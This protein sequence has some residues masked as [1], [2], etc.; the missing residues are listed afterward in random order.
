MLLDD[1]T[2]RIERLRAAHSNRRVLIGIAGPPGAGKSTLA[3]ALTDRLRAHCT[4]VPMDGFHLDDAA[5]DRLGLRHRK[6]APE[7]F[8]AEGYAA[9]LARIADGWRVWAPGFDRTVEEP[10]PRGIW[11]DEMRQVVVSEGNYLLLPEPRWQA[12]RKLFDEVWFCDLDDRLRRERL[13]KRHVEFGKSPDEAHAWVDRVDE[14][15]AALVRRS[16]HLAD[17]HVEMSELA[18][19]GS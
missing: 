2:D 12:V 17:L 6:G 10:V 3:E 18:L 11:V 19:P 16:A 15:N 13:V 4:H 8:D 5:L 14:P 1:L 9:L 7:T